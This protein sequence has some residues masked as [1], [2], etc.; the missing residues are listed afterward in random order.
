MYKSYDQLGETPEPNRDLH[1]VLEIQNNAH[2]AQILSSNRVVCVDVYADWCGPCK[3]TAPTYASLA[4]RYGKQ[5]EVILV[6]YRFENI[7]L[8]ERKTITGI[9]LFNFYVEGNKVDKVIGGDIDEVEQKLKNI[10]SQVNNQ[11]VM[12]LSK[13]NQG[14]QFTRNSIRNNRNNI[15]DT[16]GNGYTPPMPGRGNMPPNPYGQY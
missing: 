14:N 10:I 4:E 16:T 13:V 15:P 8:A 6:K 9:P 11:A 7:E 2:L 5:G 3:M 12:D 1:N